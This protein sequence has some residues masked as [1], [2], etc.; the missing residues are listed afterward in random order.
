VDHSDQDSQPLIADL[1]LSGGGV[2]GVALAGA[3]SALNDAGYRSRRVSGTSAGAIVGALVAAGLT[4]QALT[5]AAMRLDY[6]KFADKVPLDKVPMV[7]FGLVLLADDGLYLG[8]YAR[9]WIGDELAAHGVR[10]FADLALDDPQLPPEERYK[11]VVTCA[12]VTLGQLVR[13]PWDYREVYGLDPDTQLVADAVRMSMSIPLLFRPMT[14][15]NPVSGVTSTLVDGGVV[16]NFPIDSLDRTDGKPPRWPTFGITLLPDI[17]GP[18]SDLLPSWLNRLMPSMVHLLEGVIT[19]A[20]IGRDRAY[21][22][23]PWVRART[24]PINSNEVGF[25]DFGLTG[26]QVHQLHD[27]GYQAATRF[28]STWDW[29]TYLERYR[30]NDEAK[31]TSRTEKRGRQ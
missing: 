15:T 12:D 3:V 22:R 13:L 10:T 16:S 21:E 24:I 7:G 5:D 8:D 25:T 30:S 2:K 28:L 29:T 14:I 27:D 19:T 26:K 31:W 20:L 11:L 9:Q 6:A 1:V 4:G 17:P 18:D 23:K